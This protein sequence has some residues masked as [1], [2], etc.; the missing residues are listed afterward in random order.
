[1]LCSLYVPIDLRALQKHFI[2]LLPVMEAD[3]FLMGIDGKLIRNLSFVLLN[4]PTLL[5]LR[6]PINFPHS[7][8][9]IARHFPFERRLATG[10]TRACL[11]FSISLTA[12]IKSN[13]RRV[14][15]SFI[16][17]ATFMFLN[18]SSV[19]MRREKG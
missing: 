10:Y 9:C 11:L 13:R 2:S 7:Y 6:A 1:M 18:G 4:A 14:V 17:L 3:L 5:L 8:V 15:K 12:R 19:I 16:N